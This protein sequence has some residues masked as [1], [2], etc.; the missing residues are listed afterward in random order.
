VSE[1]KKRRTKFANNQVEE[2]DETD[3]I[4]L[5]QDSRYNLSNQRVAASTVVEQKSK[6][7]Q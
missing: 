4:E 5:P 1:T 3:S 2:V 6:T 7:L